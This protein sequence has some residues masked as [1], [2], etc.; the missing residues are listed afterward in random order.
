MSLNMFAILCMVVS[1]G[2]AVY[3]TNVNSVDGEDPNHFSDLKH[4]TIELVIFLLAFVQAI[5]GMMRPHGPKKL[6]T[7]VE[8]PEDAEGAPGMT[9][10]MAMASPDELK[11]T[12]H[13]NEDSDDEEARSGSKESGKSVAR[14]IWEFK[15]RAMGLTLLGLS[16]YNCDAGLDLFAE[17]YG[18]DQDLSGAFW[19]VT[20]GFAGLIFILYAFR[21]LDDKCTSSFDSIQI[22][23]ASI[24]CVCLFVSLFVCL[25]G[26]AFFP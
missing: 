16:W 14:R 26:V 18:Q 24:T 2:I 23:D 7:H 3:A 12:Q 19:G 4:R 11:K 22:T 21:L 1:F 5:I 25:F 13:P 10:E 17:R 6:A 8:V 20:G 9:A 15:H